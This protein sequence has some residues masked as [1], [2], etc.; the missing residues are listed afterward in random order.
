M[1][2]FVS[3]FVAMALI[4][5]AA[6]SL[7][8]TS[9]GK[10]RKL[11]RS[12]NAVP[13]RYIVILNRDN[14][15]S[16]TRDWSV[17]SESYELSGLY[18]ASV[19]HIFSSAV[20]GF[21]AE[22][23]SEDA[24]LMSSD[25]RV[26]YI[27]EDAEVSAADVQPGATW[28]LDRID[29][30]TLPLNSA[31]N[32]ATTG[33]GVNAYIL[34]SGIR[35]TH[36]EFGGRA[37]VAFDALN[38]G[39]NGND[40][41]GHGT[42]VAGII[43][44]STYG[45][46]KGVALRAVRVLPC[47]GIG[48]ISDLISG[49]DWVTANRINPAV[50]NISIIAGGTSSALDA[51]V[52]NSVSSGVTFVVAAGNVNQDAC[53]Y[54]PARAS[55]VITVGATTNLDEKAAYSNFGACV[56]MFAPGSGILSTWNTDDNAT[57]TQSGTSM[58]APMVAGA[59]ALYLAID[60]TATPA[61]VSQGLK[62][63]ATP[64]TVSNLDTA[65]PNKLLYS[66]LI[67]TAANVSIEGRVQ[68]PNGYAIRKALITATNARTGESKT[69]YSSVFGAFQIEDLEIGDLYVVSVRHGRVRFNNPSMSLVLLD[70]VTDIVFTSS[71]RPGDLPFASRPGK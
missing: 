69:A 44:S 54:S 58:A 33:S 47:N 3:I 17:E 9:S 45:V 6:I 28:G 32:F 13:G 24:E 1:R 36:A 27:E 8:V 38:D 42:H 59:A 26:Q 2:K 55:S 56:D 34:D 12:N 66:L 21:S 48:Q 39:Q 30:R 57:R 50:A 14:G 61:S 70:N 31:Y 41:Y 60:P 65:S 51:A 35:V 23:S 18:N 64:N 37:S 5:S 4:A 25:D 68:D 46:A 52:S 43:G 11:F 62:S 15:E 7:P 71:S 16:F 53:G 63:L 10:S 19:D 29:Q 49:I 40:C 22:M 20:K 67:P